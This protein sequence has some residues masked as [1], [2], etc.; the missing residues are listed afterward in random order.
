MQKA[1]KSFSFKLLFFN[2]IQ[3]RKY[4]VQL[5]NSKIPSNQ[6]K[7]LNLIQFSVEFCSIQSQLHETNRYVIHLSGCDKAID[8]KPQTFM[9]DVN[10]IHLILWLNL[11]KKK[12]DKKRKFNLNSFLKRKRATLKSKLNHFT[13]LSS[14]CSTN[15]QI[16]PFSE[17]ACEMFFLLIYENLW[18]SQRGEK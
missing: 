8:E 16:W 9:V 1:R 7:T 13:K 6:N 18:M 15:N 10:S 3:S 12:L 14:I 2:Y 4:F 5:L 11:I 17:P